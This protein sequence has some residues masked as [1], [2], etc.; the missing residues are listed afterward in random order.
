MI[1]LRSK[2]WALPL[3]GSRARAWTIAESVVPR[4]NVAEIAQRSDILPQQLH[5][6]RRGACMR[7]VVDDDTA[8]VPAVGRSAGQARGERRHRLAGTVGIARVPG[9]ISPD[10][11]AEAVVAATW[12]AIQK[13]RRARFRTWITSCGCGTCRLAGC[14]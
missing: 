7:M 6:W 4:A 9:D 11:V 12:A 8:F 2:A 1:A 10:L 3:A 5:A 13:V 14:E